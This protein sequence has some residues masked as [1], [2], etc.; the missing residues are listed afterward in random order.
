M[1]IL[2]AT[3]ALGAG[4][5]SAIYAYTTL[6]PDFQHVVLARARGGMQTYSWPSNVDFHAFTGS[7]P[8]YLAAIRR[9][10]LTRAPDV[11]HLHSSIAGLARV[12]SIP[13]VPT[14]YSP[15]C[16]AFERRDVGVGRRLGYRVVESLMAQRSHVLAAVSPRERQLALGLSRRLRATYVPN[17]P[18][19]ATT[20][21]IAE[22]DRNPVVVTVGRLLP[23]KDPHFF[24]AVA[25]R[26]GSHGR[27]V[28]IGDGD[29]ELRTI[30]E[31][32]GVM[33][34]G[35]LAPEEVRTMVASA[36]LY[37]HTAAWEAAPISTV[38]AAATGTPV[39]SR[40]ITSMTSLGYWT[41]GLT[42][43]ST[44]EA[45]CRFFTEP[46]TRD[47]VA[48]QT[49]ELVAGLGSEVAESALRSTYWDALALA[50]AR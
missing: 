13:R 44:A 11:L 1:T 24:A 21:G 39:M 26:C 29:P 31:R 14:V 8:H 47:A 36:S 45:V 15:H 17:V 3:E 41:S 32:A 10:V 28:W 27:F 38:E 22:Q 16:F 9:A 42:V 30:L 37:L 18:T 7:A 46:G 2:H 35:W 48:D 4:V 43:E 25:K 6:L 40:G 19:T 23:Q 50:G 49:R 20:A 5:Q 12:W 34:T 33:V